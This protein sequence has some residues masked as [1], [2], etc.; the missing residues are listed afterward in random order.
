MVTIFIRHILKVIYIVR[1]LEFDN[2]LVQND[3]SKYY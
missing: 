1:H 2:N 3:T